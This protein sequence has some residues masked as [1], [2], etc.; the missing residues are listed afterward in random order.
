MS[1]IEESPERILHRRAVEEE[2]QE[3]MLAVARLQG[4]VAALREQR[5]A[6]EVA[7]EHLRAEVEAA[8]L[9]AAEVRAAQ[10]ADQVRVEELRRTVSDLRTRLEQAE[11]AR[12]RAESERAAV[13]AALGR[14]AKRLL[15]DTPTE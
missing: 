13:I 7:E 9:E 11:E 15:Q 10:R 4:E 6:E 8:R 14:K 5:A 2:R 1:R 12:R 3:L